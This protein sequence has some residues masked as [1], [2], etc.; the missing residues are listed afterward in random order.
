MVR[1]TADGA[2]LSISAALRIEPVRATAWKQCRRVEIKPSRFRSYKG[3][4]RM[5]CVGA[6]RL[7]QIQDVAIVLVDQIYAQTAR[8]SSQRASNVPL[9]SSLRYLF[10]RAIAIYS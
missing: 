1:L 2:R 6:S 10:W 5:R 3:D 7:S 8:V 4:P 9:L